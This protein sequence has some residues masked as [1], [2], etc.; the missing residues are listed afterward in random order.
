MSVAVA[1][2]FLNNQGRIEK[3][4]ETNKIVKTVDTFNKME[5]ITS[6]L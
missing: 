4:A 1:M 5:L 6:D 3:A 2:V